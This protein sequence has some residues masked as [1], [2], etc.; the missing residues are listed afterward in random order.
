[1]LTIDLPEG[2]KKGQ[3]FR[4]VVR[5]VTGGYGAIGAAYRLAMPAEFGEMRHILGSFQLTIPVRDK[6]EMLP[7][8]ERL[9][10]NLRWIE[11][12]IPARDRWAGVFGRY[13]MQV[14]DRVDALGGDASKVAPSPTGE[15]R[16]AYPVCLGLG[17]VAALLLALL[18]L[19]IGMLA[20]GRVVAA[21]V[22]LALLAGA[23]AYWRKHC[24]P[25]YCQQ[26]IALLAGA[27]LGTLALALAAV[28]GIAGPALVPALT[29]GAALALAAALRAWSIGCFD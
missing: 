29:A 10:S 7:G 9:L 20:G 14:A 19:A 12:A 1:M 17:V 18:L 2:V 8:Q 21:A 24:R 27:V 25:T 6:A 23:V 11:R 15:W 4:V 26:L 13:V 5:Q 22:V 16:A 3:V 28:L